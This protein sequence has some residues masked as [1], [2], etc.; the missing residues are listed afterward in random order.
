MMTK[1][2]YLGYKRP[3][4]GTAGGVTT[5][6]NPGRGKQQ[7]QQQPPYY[8][9]PQP[10]QYPTSRFPGGA[11]GSSASNQQHQPLPNEIWAMK[12]DEQLSLLPCSL[13]QF[14][15]PPPFSS[16]GGGGGAN[17]NAGMVMMNK[18]IGGAA[19]RHNNGHFIENRILFI[20]VS[21]IPFNFHGAIPCSKY[22]KVSN[23]T[24]K[25]TKKIIANVKI[26]KSTL[27]YLTVYVRRTRR[28]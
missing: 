15:V 12:T 19:T 1:G 7:Q 20:N 14:A 10:P 11:I 25:Y 8:Q 17:D 22:I 26:I 27:I 2:T 18:G 23:L 28:H 9:P 24:K 6:V 16:G 21:L 4:T 13:R 3:G 5:R